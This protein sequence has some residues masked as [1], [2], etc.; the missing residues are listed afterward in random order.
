MADPKHDGFRPATDAE[1][2]A[3]ARIAPG[4][5]DRAVAAWKEDA[6]PEFRELL[7]AE[8]LDIDGADEA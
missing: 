4:D 6:P 7:D 1:I 3:L 8:P 2:A 5:I